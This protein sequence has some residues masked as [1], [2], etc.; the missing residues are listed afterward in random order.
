MA[1]DDTILIQEVCD[2]LN[3]LLKDESVGEEIRLALLKVIE[4][5]VPASVAIE[6]HPHVTC[7]QMDDG[8]L[9]IGILGILNGLFGG[10]K[11][12]IIA[13]DSTSRVLT[14]QVVS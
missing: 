3:R 12:Q 6:A 2:R 9:G 14:V 10:Q 7:T 1:L 8:T 5:R 13:E 4:Y 11:L